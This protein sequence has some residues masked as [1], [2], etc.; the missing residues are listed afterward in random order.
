MYSICSAEFTMNMLFKSLILLVDNLV[1]QW[2]NI[3]N[4]AN[5]CCDILLLSFHILLL[6]PQP[7][8]RINL[9]TLKIDV[10]HFRLQIILLVYKTW[11]NGFSFTPKLNPPSKCEVWQIINFEKCNSE[12]EGCFQM[13]ISKIICHS[14]LNRSSNQS[15]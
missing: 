2:L 7:H 15:W 5:H 12:L 9:I 11:L 1:Y 3:V 4:Q 6:F 10:T 13:R 8:I 14:K